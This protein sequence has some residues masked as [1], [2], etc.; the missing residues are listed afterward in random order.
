MAG[1]RTLKLQLLADTKNLI[2]GLNKGKKESE[3][4]GDKIDAINKKVGLAFAAMG[5]AATAM[6]LKFTKD[7]IGAASDLEETISKV[8]VIFGDTAGEID[9]FA[10]TAATRL[11]QSKTQ[12]LDAAANFAIFGKAAGLSGQALV[13]FSVNFVALASD[14][15]SFN[16]T[17]P[18]DAIMAIGAALRGEAEPLRRYGVLLNDATLKAAAM[19]LGIY[20]GNGAL[21]AQ[22]KILAAQKVILEQTGLAQG[23]FERTSDGLANSQRQIT[24]AVADAQVELGQALLP[25]M[26]QLATF[27]EQTLVPALSSFIAGLTGK[28]GLKDGLTETQKSAEAWGKRVST[29]IGVIVE[30]KDVA[31]VTAGV[32]TTMFVVSKIQAAVV[33]VI[34]LIKGLVAA[35]NA[36]RV[37][38]MAA[39]IAV[40]FAANPVLGIA[41]GTAAIA[42]MG[43]LIQQLNKQSASI[44]GGLT[45]AQTQEDYNALAG[46]RTPFA[47]VT[48]SASTGGGISTGGATTFPT[49]TGS[50]ITTN[51][52]PAPTLIEQ[53]SEEQFLKRTV[54]TGNQDVAAFRM[55]ENAGITINVNAPSAIDEEGFTR[56]VILALNNSTNRGTGG[57]GSL[58]T[59]AQIL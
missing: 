8:G 5:A 46:V 17:T 49:A 28:G 29:V 55:G 1:D 19:E 32:L 44:G 48:T 22:Q 12:A 57:G 13:D 53:V 40:A 20:A 33:L 35:Y 18:E 47:G 52:K 36:L 23:D 7:A 42:G 31:L 34:N 38:A 11:G 58:R 50:K 21:T 10:S 3:T 56:A 24:A 9:K 16:N 43:L 15:A 4:F 39:G 54:G 30:L 26:L 59:S 45:G 6:A 25:V 27:T 37:S 51:V 2:D 41:A 14:L